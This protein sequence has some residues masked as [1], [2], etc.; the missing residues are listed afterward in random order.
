MFTCSLR[1]GLTP[2][3]C[4]A[5]FRDCHPRRESTG[6]EGSFFMRSSELFD[7]LI[8]AGKSP[9]SSFDSRWFRFDK[10]SLLW[11]G[12]SRWFQSRTISPPI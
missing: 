9:K 8:I 2:I 4:S 3:V 6:S 12:K 11:R 5:W 10:F 7:A 1:L